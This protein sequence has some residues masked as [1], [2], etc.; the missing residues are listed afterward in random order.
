MV[1]VVLQAID[2]WGILSFPQ[3][4]IVSREIFLFHMTVCVM[5]LI[6]FVLLC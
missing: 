3:D 5:M 2:S 6:F 1:E 4:W